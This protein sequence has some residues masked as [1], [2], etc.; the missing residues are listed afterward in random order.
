[1]PPFQGFSGSL[2]LW[3]D[4][5]YVTPGAWRVRSGLRC[6]GPCDGLSGLTVTDPGDVA[7][8]D[9]D[10]HTCVLQVDS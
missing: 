8:L 4:C 1:M 6:G 9:E 7:L 2:R 5:V 10:N 3:W